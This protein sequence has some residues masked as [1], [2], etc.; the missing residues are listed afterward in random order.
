MNIIFYQPPTHLKKFVRYYWSCDL[1][2]H[3][4]EKIIYFD[5]Y[6]DRYPR[7]VFQVDDGYGLKNSEDKY[8]PKAYVCG[9]ET[10]PS[11]MSIQAAFSHFG[12]SFNSFALTEIFKTADE[13]M[14]NKIIDLHDLGYADLIRKLSDAK[15]HVQRIEIMCRFIEEQLSHKLFVNTNLIQ[16]VLENELAE[17]TDLFKLQKKYKITERTLERLFKSAMGISPKTFQRLVRFEKT[18]SLLK[19]PSYSNSATVGHILNYTD[20]SHFIK[21][22]KTFTNITP[23]QFQKNNF[24]LSESSAFITKI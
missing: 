20:Q 21:D 16:I 12:V 15:S 2:D 22:F 14:V 19:D 24:M 11:S 4:S 7:L 17:Q 10:S 8:V 13:L 1:L 18:L 5:N 9:I 6:A 3:Q 23:V